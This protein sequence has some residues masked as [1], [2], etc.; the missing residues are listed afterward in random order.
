MQIRAES[1]PEL[2]AYASIPIAFEVQ[3]L[4]E[5]VLLDG[6]LAGVELRERRCD[7]TFVKDYDAIPG[8]A[9]RSWP[10]QFDVSRWGWLSAWLEGA[11]VG[12]AAIAF[13]TPGL[14]MLAGR[15][16]LAMLWDLRVSP[17]ARRKGVGTALFEAAAQWAHRRGC[18]QLG[19]E[20]QNINLPACRLYA[21]RGCTLGA[22]DRFAY[23]E[24]PD[25]VQLL[26]YKPLG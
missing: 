10:D 4:L 6:G 19:V 24:L 11:R 25:E 20:T 21:S 22:I 12:G 2:D 1:P 13:R 7:P 14:Q 5:P 17:D 16:D 26:W 18:R 15:N 3:C 9:P 8:H 23:P